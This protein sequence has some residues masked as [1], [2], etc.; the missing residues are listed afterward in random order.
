MDGCS[1]S[2]RD[3]AILSP[4]FAG[5]D[6]PSTLLTTTISDLDSDSLCDLHRQLDQGLD[7]IIK[8][9]SCYVSC[10]RESLRDGG[11][12][13][14]VIAS[15]L[16]TISAVSNAC[17][18]CVLLSAHR[19]ELEGVTDF[20]AVFNLLVTEYAS[21]MNYDLY[22]Y[23]LDQYPIRSGKEV[24]KYPEY[25]DVYLKKIKIAEFSMVNPIPRRIPDTTREFIVQVDI[26]ASARLA[27]IV[28]DLKKAIGMILGINPTAFQFIDVITEGCVLVM[29]LLPAPVAQIIF[30]KHTALTEE[31]IERLRTAGVLWFK[32]NGFISHPCDEAALHGVLKSM[33]CEI[34]DPKEVQNLRFLG[35]GDADRSGAESAL[36][37]F[38]LML[39]KGRF[40]FTNVEPLKKVLENMGRYDLVSRYLEGWDKQTAE[41]AGEG[42]QEEMFGTQP[43]SPPGASVGAGSPGKV[44]Q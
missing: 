37:V 44:Q 13:P 40:S 15:D 36:E 22:E 10:I 38:Q 25:I 18:S 21:F 30:N 7:R 39:K 1:I 3:S 6:D 31:Q 19:G 42:V 32:C 9:Y 4:H 41:E 16:L 29:F 28:V 35:L 33:A 12:S 20:Y 11:I 26:P 5:A 8:R 34:V 23:M 14:S 24:L 2:Y 27:A 43:S 17:H